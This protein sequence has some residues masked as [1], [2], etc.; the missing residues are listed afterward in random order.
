MI[1][2]CASVKDNNTHAFDKSFA[3]YFHDVNNKLIKSKVNE[4]GSSLIIE[5]PRTGYIDS[6]PKTAFAGDMNPLLNST[7]IKKYLNILILKII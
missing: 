1:N 7:T 4:E 3:G 6:N 5:K 2:N